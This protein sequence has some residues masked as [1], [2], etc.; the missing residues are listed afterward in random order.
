MSDHPDRVRHP[1]PFRLNLEQ[2]RKRAKDLLRELRAGDAGAWLRLRAQHP[3]A[4]AEARLS[5]AQLV[6]ARELGLPSWP[7]L[8]AHVQ[9]MDQAWDHIARGADAL[10]AGTPTLHI[11]CGSDIRPT[12]LQAG[13]TG[14]FLEYSDPLCQGPVTAEPDW[15]D[16]R[17]GF[18]TAAY[19]TDVGRDRARIA[20]DLAAAE[21]ALQSA[22]ARYPRVVLWFE[23]DTYDQLIL[24]RVLA[25]FAAT[26]PARLELVSPARYPGAMR[27]I[28]LG[29]LPPEALRLLWREREPVLP[30]QREAG[31]A[32]WSALRAPD[33]RPLAA[34]AAS[35]SPALPQLARALRRHCQELP[36]VADGL[37]LTQRLILQIVA[38][39][40]RTAGR[41]FEALMLQREPLPWMT[42]LMLR[43][44]VA[45]MT[46]ISRPIVTTG[47]DG[48][49]RH[50]PQERLTITP[51][52]RAVLA[53]EV[54]WLS[55]APPV[56]WLG[57]VRI[58][59]AAPG[60]RWD[61][62]AGTVLPG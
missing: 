25:Q 14:D 31:R 15:L 2:Q 40:S 48:E 61:D 27:F 43:D 57:G 4:P 47:F 3:G 53:G 12:L 42:D 17:A 20:A 51:L 18:L 30:P 19:G 62:A 49:D 35:G 23:H 55:L 8:K 13:F 32:A 11:R 29:Q 6:I 59:G 37:G 60:W 28:G 41:V 16:A 5:D 38:E 10:D 39:Q 26:P 36:W 9:A 21:A 46:G 50:W 45:T 7:K 44:M 58:D 24:A 22:A 56:R 33:P 34:M 52:G 54:D 1:S